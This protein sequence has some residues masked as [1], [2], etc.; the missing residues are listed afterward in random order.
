MRCA[1]LK[2]KKPTANF[3]GFGGPGLCSFVAEHVKENSRAE[4]KGKAITIVKVQEVDFQVDEE[5]LVMCM[6]RTYPWKWTWQAKKY[7][8]GDSWS[9]SHLQQ[10]LMRCQSMT[11]SH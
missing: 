5:L 7:Q 2:Q 10:G 3:V 9:T 1:W 4:E 6:R 8:H 11:G